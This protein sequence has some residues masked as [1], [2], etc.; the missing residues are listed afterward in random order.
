MTFAFAKRLL[1]QAQDVDV[2]AGIGIALRAHLYRLDMGGIF[3]FMTELAG[4]ARHVRHGR[5]FRL[6]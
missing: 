1:L 5:H 3:W 6:P 4:A 2:S